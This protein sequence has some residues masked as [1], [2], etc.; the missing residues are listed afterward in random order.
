MREVQ[1]G[2]KISTTSELINTPEIDKEK[3]TLINTAKDRFKGLKLD[4]DVLTA[5]FNTKE[6]DLLGKNIMDFYKVFDNII[7]EYEKKLSQKN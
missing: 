3:E 2:I 4:M 7:E 5:E 1:G 6:D